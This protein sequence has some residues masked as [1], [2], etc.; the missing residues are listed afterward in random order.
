MTVGIVRFA[1]APHHV[2][3]KISMI[4]QWVGDPT[5]LQGLPGVDG[6]PGAR[7]ATGDTGPPGPAVSTSAVCSTFMYSYH[8]KCDNVCLRTSV[9][10]FDEGPC[11]VTSDTGSCSKPKDLSVPQTHN[12]CCVCAP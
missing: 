2:D 5:G 8:D 1:Y 11:S 3:H 12:I 10:A 9:V 7:G 4:G 6:A